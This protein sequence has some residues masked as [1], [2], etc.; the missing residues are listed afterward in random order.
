MLFHKISGWFSR[1]PGRKKAKQLIFD[2]D[3]SDFENLATNKFYD[4]FLV[5]YLKLPSPS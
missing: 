3:Y 5:G 2:F 4:R 1:M